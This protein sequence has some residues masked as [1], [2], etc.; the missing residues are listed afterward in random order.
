MYDFAHQQIFLEHVGVKFE[1]LILDMY[2]YYNFITIHMK[3]VYTFLQSPIFIINKD[4]QVGVR[5][6]CA[7]YVYSG[8]FHSDGLVV[9]LIGWFMV[10]FRKY[11]K[12]FRQTFGALFCFLFGFLLPVE[13]L[14]YLT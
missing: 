2:G 14:S 8:C 11:S 13:I 9:S 1:F 4:G 12:K 7:K 10:S 3:S 6:R 5:I